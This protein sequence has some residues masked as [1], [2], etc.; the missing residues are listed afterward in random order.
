MVAGQKPPSEHMGSQV[1]GPELVIGVV[2]AVDLDLG[3]VTDD[4]ARALREVNYDSRRIRLSDILRE[5]KVLDELKPE[6][7]QDQDRAAF[8]DSHQNAGDKLRKETRHDILSLLAIARI[9]ATRKQATGPDNPDIALEGPDDLLTADHGDEDSQGELEPTVKE[10]YRG[11]RQPIPRTAFLLRSLKHPEEAKTLRDVYG[12][13]FVLVSA[14]AIDDDT[15]DDFAAELAHSRSHAVRSIDRDEAR[16]IASRDDKDVENDSGQNVRET[17]PLGDFFLKVGD[18]GQSRSEISRFVELLFASPYQTPL[19]QEFGMYTAYAASLRSAALGRQ[20]GAAILDGE[21]AVVAVGT[22]EVPKAGG[23]QYW[24][25]SYD[26]R[27][28]KY[29]DGSDSSD[30]MRRAILSEMLEHYGRFGISKP[31]LADGT[32]ASI[33]D[34]VPALKGTRVGNLVEFGRTVHAEMAAIADA[35]RRGVSVHGCTLFTT[36]FP[37]HNCARHIV[38]AGVSEV[39][40]LEP[41]AKSMAI[42][43]HRDSIRVGGDGQSN[44]HIVFRQYAGVAPRRYPELFTMVERKDNLGYRMSFKPERSLPRDVDLQPFYQYREWR[45]VADAS[46]AL[47]DA[48]IGVHDDFVDKAR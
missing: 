23:G 21:G 22:N 36:T 44:K 15:I 11:L 10:L 31:R 8:I 25:G 14:H 27:D 20:V 38:A 42:E 29:E 34:L 6:D 12:S 39:V 45:A 37:C 40:F 26:K 4:L 35:A 17:Y 3:A 48:G 19:I 24:P 43:L 46:R 18:E 32:E 7:D 41:Y 28:H 30:T 33:D 1:T 13:R 2:G 9:R 5:V 47:R 16:R